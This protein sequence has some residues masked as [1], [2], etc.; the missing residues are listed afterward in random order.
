MPLP[1]RQIHLDFHTSELI[2]GIGS[3]F[4]PAAFARTLQEAR[5]NSITCFSK[6]HHGMIYHDTRFEARHPF[7]ERNLLAEQIEACHAAGIRIPIYISVGLD[8]FVAARH[9]E[10]IELGVDGKRRGATPLQ[11]GWKKLCFNTPYM[12]YVWEQTREVLDMFAVDGL[13]F[14]IISQGQCCC[15]WC[16]AGMHEAGVDPESEEERKAYARCILDGMKLDFTARIRE[17]N[18]TCDVFWNSGHVDP[19]FRPVLGAY[20]HLELESLPSGGWGYDH[21]PI[22][23]RYARNL[24][25]DHVGMTGKF[26]KTWAGFG[27]YKNQAAL[28]YECFTSL[29]EG[30]KCSIGD[31]LPPSGQLDAGTYELVGAVYRQVEAKEPW[32][33]GAEAV[34]E[35][36]IYNPEALG[37][38]DGRVDSAAGGA[39]RMLL[40]THHQFDVVDEMM[41]WSRYR[42]L[43]LADK[44]RLSPQ[45]L[46]KVR[47]YLAAGGK[48]VASHCSGLAADRDEFVLTELGVRYEGEARHSPDYVVPRAA[49]A[50]G[51]LPGQHVMYE[52]GV[53]VS[54]EGPD[55]EVLADVWHPYF[56]RTYEHF[57]S[58]RHTPPEKAAGLPAAVATENTLYFAHPLF[59]SFMRHGLRVYKQLFLNALDR[60][61][62][63]PLVRS[64]APTTAH[65][66]VTRQAEPARTIVHVLHYV[67]EQ[68]YRETPTIED[69]LPL[70]NVTLSVRTPAPPAGVSLA[71]EG[72][73]LPF[74]Y[75]D[76]RIVVTVPEVIGHAMVVLVEGTSQEGAGPA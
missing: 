49:I 63:D 68:R 34:T 10:W 70:Y 30:S 45:L 7:L 36:A 60:W 75:R 4:D 6:C 53:E 67:P 32:C 62:T 13:F 8:E 55:P 31:Q 11:A 35:I 74:T 54:L 22:T 50:G 15:R 64:T 23:V 61:L 69:V 71:P 41:D 57:C 19:T 59:A 72:T 65:I 5:V 47:A 58:H 1:F 66:T 52:R 37:V 16:M 25:L 56:D 20:S 48:V 26:H 44:I 43:I 42:V 12:D 38:H 24:G 18:A 21:F 2:A 39:Y 3:R 28:E 76:G 29:A 33:T 46:A 17:Q 9:P 73:D 51:I 27:E 14:D 40:E